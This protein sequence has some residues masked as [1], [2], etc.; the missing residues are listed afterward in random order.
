ML[1]VVFLQVRSYLKARFF[2]P[3]ALLL[4]RDSTL[5]LFSCH[6]VCVPVLPGGT[7]RPH[8][9]RKRPTL[10]NVSNQ[11]MHHSIQQS[12][13][14]GFQDAYSPEYPSLHQATPDFPLLEILLSNLILCSA[15]LWAAAVLCGAQLLLC[16]AVMR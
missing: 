7:C 2:L 10:G 8:P 13:S 3:F 6:C 14:L 4:P 15:L 9:Y 1:T 11:H 5:S 12:Y 16:Q